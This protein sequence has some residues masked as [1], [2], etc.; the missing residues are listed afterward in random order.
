MGLSKP[1]DPVAHAIP[2]V[3]VV[4]MPVDYR[5]S[6]GQQ[7]DAG[8]YDISVRM[9]SMLAPHPAIGLTSAVAIAAAATVA[10]SVVADIAGARPAASRRLRLGTPAGVVSTDITLSDR[11]LPDTVTLHRAA[12]RIATAELFIADP[13]T[14]LA[15]SAS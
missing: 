13:A 2:K 11:G 6:S 4:G 7:I 5:T 14:V 1:S 8:D 12:R 3:G 9:V 10:S 15:G